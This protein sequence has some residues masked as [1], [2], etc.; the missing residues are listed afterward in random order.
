[1]SNRLLVAA[2]P[3][4]VRVRR[5]RMHAGGRQG[6]WPAPS[7]LPSS[8]CDGASHQ[9]LLRG[10]GGRRALRVGGSGSEVLR[11]RR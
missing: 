8:R 4:R 2:A 9:S 7:V 6:V 10:V 3:L 5:S 1:M 11:C